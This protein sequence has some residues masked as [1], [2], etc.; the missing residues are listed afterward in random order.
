MQ[1]GLSLG[2]QSAELSEPYNSN[3]DLGQI[4]IHT[5]LKVVSGQFMLTNCKA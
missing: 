1:P 5:E 2:S 3:Q 4:L